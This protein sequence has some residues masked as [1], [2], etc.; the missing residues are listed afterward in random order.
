MRF[1]YGPNKQY[2][3]YKVVFNTNNVTAGLFTRINYLNS[4][5]FNFNSFLQYDYN[6]FRVVLSKYFIEYA[7]S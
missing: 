6:P 2:V 3:D 7:F 5:T 1:G 4:I